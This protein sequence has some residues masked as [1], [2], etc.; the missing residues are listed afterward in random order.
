[1]LKPTSPVTTLDNNGASFFSHL[2]DAL[3]MT[4][5]VSG[6]AMNVLK[7]EPYSAFGFALLG[8]IVYYQRM[9]ANDSAEI[10]T[11]NVEIQNDVAGLKGQ[12][13]EKEALITKLKDELTDLK[14]TLVTLQKTIKDFDSK[15]KALESAS[16]GIFDESLTLK[17][18]ADI[19]TQRI[20]VLEDD[21]SR[22]M[23]QYE[24]MKTQFVK[25]VDANVAMGAELKTFDTNATAFAGEAK[26]FELKLTDTQNQMNAGEKKLSE[27]VHLLETT[28][29]SIEAHTKAKHEEL[30]E[31]KTLIAT[32]QQQGKEL[33]QQMEDITQL[34][35]D[36]LKELGENQAK[37]IEGRHLL[38]T[39]TR[40]CEQKEAQL[41]ALKSEIK[42]VQTQLAAL[43]PE[44]RTT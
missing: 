21:L 32:L 5:V 4:T 12:L 34:N 31:L 17:E 19:L 11:L 23:Q 44:L 29:Q 7:K 8:G 33:P 18:Q 9:T 15:N 36:I 6:I 20:K 35:Q 1:M 24:A 26:T 2:I 30:A 25:L 10:H 13:E 39:L 40:L 38:Q 16:D 3:S 43:K 22:Y 42:E 41:I 28:V 27:Y 14:A 37:A